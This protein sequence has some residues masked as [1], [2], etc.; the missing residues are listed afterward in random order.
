MN[1]KINC[2]AVCVSNSESDFRGPKGHLSIGILRSGSI[3]PWIYVVCWPLILLKGFQVLPQGLAFRVP[4][5][6]GT[7]GGLCSGV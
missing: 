2:S 6:R 1:Y 5:S 7:F 3:H 4:C